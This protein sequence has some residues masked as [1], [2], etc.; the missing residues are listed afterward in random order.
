MTLCVV[1]SRSG[2]AIRDVHDEF[3]SGE[4]NTVEDRQWLARRFEA[5]AHPA[6]ETSSP[7]GWKAVLRGPV[8]AG[9]TRPTPRARA[10]VA[11]LDQ[12]SERGRPK[13]GVGLR[14]WESSGVLIGTSA[15]RLCHWGSRQSIGPMEPEQPDAY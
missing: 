5:V 12:E 14:A 3:K 11:L 15:M 8:A 13:A 10:V 7:S 6:L 9:G 2:V 4:G 1:L